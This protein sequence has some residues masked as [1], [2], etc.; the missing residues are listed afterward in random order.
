MVQ[1]MCWRCFLRTSDIAAMSPGLDFCAQTTSQR[2]RV[3]SIIAHKR[4][5]SD[6]VCLHVS[7]QTTAVDVVVSV[8]ICLQ[9]RQRVLLPCM[10]ACYC[11]R[12]FLRFFDT[13]KE[14]HM[15]RKL[16]PSTEPANSKPYIQVLQPAG[17]EKIFHVVTFFTNS[18]IVSIVAPLPRARDI[19][20]TSPKP[21]QF[22]VTVVG[23]NAF[24]N[25]D[26]KETHLTEYTS[27]HWPFCRLE[28]NTMY[29]VYIYNNACTYVDL[30]F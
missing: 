10:Q 30:H 18:A 27:S 20:E 29:N 15:F 6:A 28:Q 4:H 25:T 2:C 7:G 26:T 14:A 21:K 19:T 5:R 17:F 13:Q 16:W 23:A 3:V 9:F 24:Q 8:I 1:C 11:N 22:G 12:F